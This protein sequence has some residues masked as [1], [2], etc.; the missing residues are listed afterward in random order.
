MR[1]MSTRRRVTRFSLPGR[2]SRRRRLEPQ[3]RHQAGPAS[4][5]RRHRPAEQSCAR[6]PSHAGL[7]GD[8]PGDSPQDGSGRS[9]RSR[10]YRTAAAM[11]RPSGVPGAQGE[12][13]RRACLAHRARQRSRRPRPRRPSATPRPHAL[14]AATPVQ[15]GMPPRSARPARGDRAATTPSH[16]CQAPRAYAGTQ[17]WRAGSVSFTGTI[18]KRRPGQSPP[19]H[20]VQLPASGCSPCSSS[21]ARRGRPADPVAP[22][23]DEAR[24]PESRSR[25]W[26]GRTT[27]GPQTGF[28]SRPGRG[29]Q[30]QGPVADQP[31]APPKAGPV[32]D[33]RNRQP[34]RNRRVPP[35][36][37]PAGPGV[38]HSGCRRLPGPPCRFVE[39]ESDATP[40]THRSPCGVAASGR[41]SIRAAP[42]ASLGTGRRPPPRRPPAPRR[43]SGPARLPARDRR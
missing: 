9:G 1:T 37:Q 18:Q 40:G 33:R 14:A 17:A 12:G 24:R 23:D 29:Q 22:L 32:P 7:E 16:A 41:P 31:H 42:A 2:P 36:D 38:D 34:C 20:G 10:Q 3:S 21:M 11:R 19:H 43:R 35:D 4:G 39:A 27:P 28:G 8:E 30:L 5:A 15:R 25:P 6:C 26:P 13:A